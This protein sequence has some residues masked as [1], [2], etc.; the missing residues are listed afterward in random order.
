V[1]GYVSGH[2][3][4]TIAGSGFFRH[5]IPQI[6]DFGVSPHP[7]HPYFKASE[8]LCFCEFGSSSLL[9]ALPA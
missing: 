1:A 5:E 4:V 9:P 3:R 6:S 7:L 8:H 2:I